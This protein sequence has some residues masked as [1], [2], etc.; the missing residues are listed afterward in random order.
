MSDWLKLHRAFNIDADSWIIDTSYY[1][2][3][4]YLEWIGIKVDWGGDK[5]K[6]LSYV[7]SRQN[8][9]YY[10]RADPG[11]L[12]IATPKEKAN[13]IF[14]ILAYGNPMQR[15]YEDNEYGYDKRHKEWMKIQ[16]YDACQAVVGNMDYVYGWDRVFGSR[17]MVDWKENL[18]L[19]R[20]GKIPDR[21]IS[22]HG[23]GRARN[24]YSHISSDGKYFKRNHRDL[25]DALIIE[26]IEKETKWNWREKRIKG[27][28]GRFNRD[29]N[30]IPFMFEDY[31]YLWNHLTGDWMDG[32]ESGRVGGN[33]I[34]LEGLPY[35]GTVG[36]DDSLLLIP[37]PSGSL[38]EI[39]DFTF[40]NW[41]LEKP[42][43]EK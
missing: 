18:D 23:G 13:T 35:Y 25:L 12:K 16:N 34:F 20:Y 3:D 26:T 41:N 24:L 33:I 10:I 30:K 36:H 9:F 8:S 15:Q 14:A 42:L 2:G 40:I 11:Q 31:A 19:L 6:I 37:L 7:D 22:P 32:G 28:I 4:E 5:P 21:E 39:N 29:H 27:A 38:R 43:Q 17:S 1:G